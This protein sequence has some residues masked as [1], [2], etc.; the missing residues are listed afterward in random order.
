MKNERQDTMRNLFIVTVVLTLLPVLFVQADN[1][2]AFPGAEGHGRF[3]TGGRG[4]VV[5]HVTNLEDDAT[6]PPFGSLRYFINKTETRT[7]VFDVSGTI[8]LKDYLNINSGNL[9]I[10][11]QTAPGDGICIAGYP[12]HVNA[13]N[14]I[15]RFLRIRMGDLHPDVEDD[16]L[17]GRGI[18][19][20]IID[21][22]S[23]SWSVDECVSFYGDENLTLQWCI[24]S[25]SLRYSNHQKGGHGYGGIWGGAKTSFHHNFLTH[26]SSRTP[27][28]GAMDITDGR[29]NVDLRNNV[30]YN[31][32]EVVGCYGAEGMD[33]NIVNCY[34]KP[35]PGTT[36]GDRR[37]MLISI[38]VNNDDSAR[39]RLGKYYIEG[40]WCSSLKDTYKTPTNSLEKATTADN[41]NTKSVQCSDI[42]AAERAAMRLSE[43]NTLGTV[44]THSAQVAFEKVMNTAGCSLVRDIIDERLVRE[45]RNG[46]YTFQGT[47]DPSG[48]SYPG[49]IDSQNDLK[50]RNAGD[51]WNPW[52]TLNSTECP[53]D[54]DRD[55]MPD[56]WEEA[57]GLNPKY[58]LDG[59]AVAENGY[60]NLE[61]Y[62]NSL[63]QHIVAQELGDYEFV[64]GEGKNDLDTSVEFAELDREEMD[65][66]YDLCGRPVVNPSEGIYI[67]KGKKII[68]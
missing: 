3:V 49:I 2:P 55:G 34:Y 23:C 1:M 26:H 33:A 17:G 61:N 68:L 24:V 14:I 52:P 45:C 30:I 40:N 65:V 42:T 48:R 63:V 29:D 10:A 66:Y 53:L 56:A 57:H 35:G 4:G 67:Y 32:G 18:K 39:P 8:F 43:P 51:D 27:R 15:M 58:P 50:P 37:A 41:W 44:T 13:N 12:V 22:C 62:L 47:S 54:T 28:L 59:K 7:I 46:S 16:A 64:T 11:G 5:Y 20:I 38:G 19:N 60:T 21:H 31:Y 25:E 6:N 36:T 9:T